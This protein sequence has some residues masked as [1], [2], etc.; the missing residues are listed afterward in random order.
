MLDWFWLKPRKLLLSLSV[1]PPMRSFVVALWGCNDTIGTCGHRRSTEWKEASQDQ[2]VAV[3]PQPFHCT[4]K[5]P[6]IS[7]STHTEIHAKWPLNCWLIWL[8]FMLRAKNTQNPSSGMVTWKYNE[9]GG[10]RWL[11]HVQYCI[12]RRAKLHNKF[13][14]KNPTFIPFISA[15]ANIWH[16]SRDLSRERQRDEVMIQ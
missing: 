9:K 4:Q 10:L 1:D 5:I 13:H 12:G 2:Y 15:V 6:Q 11:P 14:K 16:P 8:C 7:H 3:G